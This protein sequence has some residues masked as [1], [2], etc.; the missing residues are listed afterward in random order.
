MFP[1]SCLC[2]FSTDFQ[3]K[4]GTTLGVG[5]GC[6]SHCAVDNTAQGCWRLCQ[7][8]LLQMAEP[9]LNQVSHCELTVVLLC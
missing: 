8:S 7:D 3:S 9:D 4:P 6:R 2:R 5:E 1:C